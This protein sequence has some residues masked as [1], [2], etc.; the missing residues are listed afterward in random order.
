[1]NPFYF[2]LSPQLMWTML[3]HWVPWDMLTEQKISSTDQQLMK[4]VQNNICSKHL[5]SVD[6]GPIIQNYYLYN[7]IVMEYI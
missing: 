1:M 7:K 5:D 6:L 4:W 2:Q 3:K